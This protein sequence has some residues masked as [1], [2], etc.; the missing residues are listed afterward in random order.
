MPVV[1]LLWS[2]LVI[3]WMPVSGFTHEVRPAII[4]LNLNPNGYELDIRLNLEAVMAEISPE[5]QD[6]D[7]SDN[8]PRYNQLRAL[9]AHDLTATFS[10]F[11]DS[12]LE[13][14]EVTDIEGLRVQHA[15]SRVEVAEVGDLELA[16][17]S[18][19]VLK[20]VGEM[21]RGAVTWSW[22]KAYG[23]NIIRVNKIDSEEDVEGYS[24]FLQGGEVSEPIPLSGEIKLSA[25]DVLTNYLVVGFT[26]ILPKGLD[27]ILFVVGLFL[28]SPMLRPLLIQ[29]TSFTVAHTVTLALGA[30]G[31]IQIFP[32]IVEPL[33]AA[34]IVY[35]CVE[36]IFSSKL[37]RWRP[38][39]VFG[40]GLLHGLGF[41]GVLAEVGIASSFFVTALLSFNVGVELGQLSVILGC[42]LLVGI[43]FRNKPWYRRV[44]TIPASLVIALI[45]AFWFFQR[46]FST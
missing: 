46:I 12:F 2:A 14:V 24:A 20:T 6:T 8:A 18:R 45:G 1:L 10:R 40:F 41:A 9:S 34:S 11:Q 42:F 35:V 31:V 30:S 13:A 23:T 43:W 22:V 36:N 28:L 32:S 17:D 37:Q 16:R 4:N 26:H 3:F 19:I 29:I 33:I 39:I 5:H 44:V 15:V 25:W 21:P 7:E 38:V 27:H